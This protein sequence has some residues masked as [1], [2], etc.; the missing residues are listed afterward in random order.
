MHKLKKLSHKQ[1]DDFAL[2]HPQGNWH[3][4]STMATFR[5]KLGWD[6]HLL[7][8]FHDDSLTGAALLAGKAGRYEV[9]MGPLVDFATPGVAQA[10]LIA[11]TDY[12]KSIGG[13]SLQVYPYSVYQ[14]RDSSGAVTDGPHTAALA[15]LKAAGFT[16]KGFSVEY[17][18]SANRWV[19][20]KDLSGISTEDDLLMSY[21]QTT[22][23]IIKKL[24]HSRYLVKKLKYDELSIIKDLIDASNDKNGVL[25]RPLSYYQHLYTEF[26]DTVEFLVVYYDDTT[27]LS[28]AAF[29]HHHNETVYFISGTDTNYRHLYGGHYL[30]HYVMLQEIQQK[31]YR[32]NFYGISGHFDHNPLLVYKAGFKGFIEEYTGGFVK[33]IRPVQFYGR[34]AAGVAK[35]GIDRASSKL[36]RGS[37]A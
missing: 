21:R 24:D 19:Y 13:I 5:E 4:T 22:R 11:L 8:S 35:R 31:Q 20:V 17:D 2:Q 9:T 10:F 28:G 23:Q 33:I 16:H 37:A 14:L 29:I 15:I 25:G 3:Q 18:H 32:Y 7:G 34:R 36:R 6:V 1:F 30:Q 12:T 26:G 27:P